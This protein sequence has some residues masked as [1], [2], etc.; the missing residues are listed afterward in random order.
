MLRA[1]SFLILSL[2]LAGCPDQQ[3]SDPA[4]EVEQTKKKAMKGDATAQFV[5]G[6]MCDNGIDVPKD[7]AQAVFWYRK[8]AEQGCTS[9]QFKLAIMYS[10]GRGVQ[11]D[12]AQALFW[13]RKSAER[14]NAHAQLGMGFRYLNANGVPKDEIEAYAWFNLAAVSNDVAKW[15]RDKLEKNLTDAGRK[16]AQA[17]TRELQKLIEERKAAEG[18]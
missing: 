5:L 12:E 14:G 1:A 2:L 6:V 10:H 13:Y 15:Q 9:S 4:K 8:A 16:L 7:E 11:M 3:T 18:K 17:R